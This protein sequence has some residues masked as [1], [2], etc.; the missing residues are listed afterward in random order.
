[1]KKI[2]AVKVLEN[3]HIWLR[4][5][6]GVEGEVDFSSKPHPGVYAAWRDYEC[7]RRAHIG[8]FGELCSDDQLDFCPDALWLQ[9]TRR[10]LDDLDHTDRG[11]LPGHQ[12]TSTQGVAPSR[13]RTGCA[14]RALLQSR[15]GHD[16]YD[17]QCR[18]GTSP[19][20]QATRDQHVLGG[21]R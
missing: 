19:V 12:A 13:L 21:V 11:D 10:K 5:D 14:R 8:D 18:D 4:F 9:V 7:F 15:A 6:D 16:R 1:M 3:Y 20:S 17:S 2:T